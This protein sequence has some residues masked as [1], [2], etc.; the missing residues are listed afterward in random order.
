MKNT[1]LKTFI[2]GSLFSF[3]AMFIG[4]I[5]NYL[6]RRYLA[7]H[8]SE[9][10]FGLFYGMFSFV[11]IAGSFAEFGLTQSGTVLFAEAEQQ[12]KEFPKIF[13]ALIFLRAIF[14]FIIFAAL[15][16][17]NTEIRKGFGNISFLPYLLLTLLVLLQIP[18]GTCTSF[19]NGI[20]LFSASYGL[21]I[22][23]SALIFLFVCLMTPAFSLPGTCAAFI[24]AP[25]I[26]TS[27]SLSIL[28]FHFK[29][30]PTICIDKTLWK[31]VLSLSSFVAIS[32]MLLNVIYHIGTVLLTFIKGAE[33]TSVY[34]IGVSF[35]QIIQV[36]MVFPTIFL[37]IAVQM[38]QEKKYTSLKKVLYI[39]VV[40]AIL[41]LPVTAVFFHLA[42]PAL[43]TLLFSE[44][45]SMAAP[46]VTILC[47]G[48]IFY[49][50]SNFLSQIIISLN[51]EKAM[52]VNTLITV[53]I[54]LPL[55]IILISRLDY[56]GAASASALSYV[57]LSVLHASLLYRII[58]K[59]LNER[60]VSE[61][62]GCARERTV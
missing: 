12:K 57:L 4:G 13:S 9:Y 43:I 27:V 39:S 35:M 61:S 37:P 45:Y 19:W 22:C 59:L 32:I 56:I 42:S 18:E 24:A 6:V 47:S 17:F 25:L 21:F 26:T 54:N 60:V 29:I 11:L 23:K 49:S 7:L 50:L 10:H 40:L 55:N 20:K 5:I 16:I 1:H 31:R 62:K 30:R 38:N 46:T 8:L 58:Q 51:Q 33:S 34:N 36:T 44:K 2:R 15:L 14:C 3:T 48:L 52:M 53:I 28:C 41:L